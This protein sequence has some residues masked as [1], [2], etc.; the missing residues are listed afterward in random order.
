MGK[1]EQRRLSCFTTGHRFAYEMTSTIEVKVKPCSGTL[2]PADDRSCQEPEFQKPHNESPGMETWR[3]LQP[4][5]RGW[6]YSL[7]A[8]GE[9]AIVR[10][11]S[12]DLADG[13]F[14]TVTAH[15]EDRI[16]SRALR[17]RRDV[18]RV[19]QTENCLGSQ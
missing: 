14:I 2:H 12:D 8:D 5:W 4:R 3:L 19:Q 6:L 9:R 7:F 15:A 18:Q 16:S 1:K 10:V 17:A 11:I 13:V